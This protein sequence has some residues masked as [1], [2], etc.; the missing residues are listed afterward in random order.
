VG[1]SAELG[2]DDVVIAA[3]EGD[4]AMLER[5]L[6]RAFAE[7]EMAVGVLRAAMRHFQRL[8]LTAARLA[9]GMSEEEALRSLRPPLFYKAQ[10]SF[11]RALRLWPERRAAQALDALVEA[12]INAKRTGLPPEAICREALLR[13]ARRAQRARR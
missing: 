7:G 1:D 3:A 5:A 10:E 2:L 6:E 8:H 4:A 12:E 9:S 11:K 13:L